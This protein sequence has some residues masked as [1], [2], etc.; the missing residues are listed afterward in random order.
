MT[1]PTVYDASFPIPNF[2]MIFRSLPFRFSTLS[3]DFGLLAIHQSSLRPFTF[4]DAP[5]SQTR[6]RSAVYDPGV[7]T[8]TSFAKASKPLA[9]SSSTA[10]LGESYRYREKCSMIW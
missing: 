5:S 6:I 4:M 10:L 1:S 2:P 3:P 8:R 7:K 9:T